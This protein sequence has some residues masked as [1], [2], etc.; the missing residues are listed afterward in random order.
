M[1][2]LNLGFIPFP[3]LFVQQIVSVVLGAIAICYPK[4]LAIFKAIGYLFCTHLQ[5]TK[6]STKYKNESVVEQFAAFH[7]SLHFINCASS[8]WAISSGVFT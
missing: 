5:Q 2:N 1:L 3:S 6:P 7:L 4:P 8:M